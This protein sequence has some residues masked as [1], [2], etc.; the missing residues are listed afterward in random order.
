MDL[1]YLL[2]GHQPVPCSYDEWLRKA[3]FGQPEWRVGGTAI[4]E[5]WVSTVFLGTN[6]GLCD[7]GLPVLF[8]T[9]I[10][11]LDIDDGYQTR[12]STW[13]EAETMHQVAVDHATAI[14]AAANI[15]KT[16]DALLA[17]WKQ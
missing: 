10:M 2:D 9:L 17:E 12:C 14:I 13:A 1:T 8:E 16:F 4:W 15:D 11:G 5:V 3:R 7:R 6:M